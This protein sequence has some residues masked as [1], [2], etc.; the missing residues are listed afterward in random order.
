MPLKKPSRIVHDLC[1]YWLMSRDGFKANAQG[2][3]AS[4]IMAQ[5]LACVPTT[6]RRCRSALSMAGT[7]IP[8]PYSLHPNQHF[9]CKPHRV[10]DCPPFE[11]V[12]P[13]LTEVILG[14][15]A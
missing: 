12:L 1:A 5:A 15:P 3:H 7:I 13:G 14:P 4:R 2:Q 9:F 6:A 8:Y 10:K 11:G